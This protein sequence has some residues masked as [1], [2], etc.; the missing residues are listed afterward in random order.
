[1][2]FLIVTILIFL[3]LFIHYLQFFVSMFYEERKCLVIPTD[4]QAEKL[5]PF[6]MLVF[7][8]IKQ[9]TLYLT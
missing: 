3:N 9:I 5:S 7:C 8:I 1:M 4:L 2:E 6:L